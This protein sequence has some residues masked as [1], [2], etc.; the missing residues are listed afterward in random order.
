MYLLEEYKVWHFVRTHKAR[1]V[2]IA[3]CRNAT[4]FYIAYTVSLL[5]ALLAGLGYMYTVHSS[6]VARLFLCVPF[7]DRSVF[8]RIYLKYISL[9]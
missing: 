5:W 9:N 1:T 2:V 6:S 4:P 8:Q 7:I 3:I